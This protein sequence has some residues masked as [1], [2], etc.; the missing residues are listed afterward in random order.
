MENIFSTVHI[1]NCANLVYI[2]QY[3]EP[4]HVP[5][6]VYALNGNFMY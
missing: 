6:N 3:F 2:Y 1:F 4:I 5:E